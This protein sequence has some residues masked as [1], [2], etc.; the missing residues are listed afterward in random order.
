MIYRWRTGAIAWLLHRLSGLALA[1][2]LPMHIWVNHH[3]ARGPE[4][5]NRVMRILAMPAF[6]ILEVGLWGII[7]YHTMNGIRIL[8]IDLGP[9]LKYQ[10]QLFWAVVIVGLILWGAGSY[11][12][13]H[14]FMDKVSVH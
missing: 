5:Y 10:K 2:Y 9:G 14:S 6:K 13:V 3:L 12:F 4:E 8:L 1:A 7:L 11:P